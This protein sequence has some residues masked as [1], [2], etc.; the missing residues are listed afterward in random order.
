MIQI[1]RGSKNN[2]LALK[3]PLAAGQPGYD[4]DKHKI[5]IGNGKDL[6][7]SL[8][9]ASGL[10]AKEIFNSE[11]DA[12]ERNKTDNSDTTIITYGT[13]SPDKNTIGQLYL[14]Y[15]D[16][17]PEA[18]YVVSS[19]VDRE[20]TYQ[21]WNSGIARCCGTFKFSTTVQSI[22]GESLYQ[23]SSYMDK[24]DYPFSFKD[25]P[26]E[27]ASVQS[28]GGV[29]WLAGCKNLNTTKQTATYTIVSP[30]KQSN[31]AE[32]KVTIQVEGFWK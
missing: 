24:I 30:E 3:K 15:Y 26:N 32:Y 28:P 25:I 19:G 21:K 4:K 7:S 5:K 8:P 27:Y 12:K 1:K 14:Q 17:D 11:A 29:V 18:D 31:T 2:W 10:F 23:S 22:I 6:W 16:T 9:Y 20:W 13:D